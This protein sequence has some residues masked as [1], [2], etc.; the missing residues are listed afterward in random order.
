MVDSDLTGFTA[1]LAQAATLYPGFSMPATTARAYFD[2]LKRYSLPSVKTAIRKAI[3]QSPE[4]MPAAPVMREIAE[5]EEKAAHA[6]RNDPKTPVSHQL[7]E[8]RW[9]GVPKTL[10][11]QQEY[12]KAAGEDKYETLARIWECE[13]VRRGDHPTG[14]IPQEDGARRMRQINQLVGNIAKDKSA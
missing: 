8:A 11:G 10:H 4:R 5:V 9:V 12:V 1:Y 2:Y 14:S 6:R 13:S 7:G 3:D